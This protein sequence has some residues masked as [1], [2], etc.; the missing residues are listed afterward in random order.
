MVDRTLARP[1]LRPPALSL[2]GWVPF[3]EEDSV[4]MGVDA[5]D[6]RGPHAL[7]ASGQADGEERSS[8]FDTTSLSSA[9]DTEDV[10]TISDEQREYYITQFKTMQVYGEDGIFGS[11]DQHYIVQ[12]S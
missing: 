1:C 4:S 9:S 12:C 11:D 2:S 8:S 7:G 6:P 3:D 10:W 5:S